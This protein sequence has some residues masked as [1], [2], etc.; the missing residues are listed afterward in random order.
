MEQSFEAYACMG[1]RDYACVERLLGDGHA[2]NAREVGVLI[3]A[4][5]SSGNTE[6]ACASMASL[7]ERFPDSPETARHRAIHLQTCPH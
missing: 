2:Q 4:Q 3:R 1:R 5:R 6:G 7:F